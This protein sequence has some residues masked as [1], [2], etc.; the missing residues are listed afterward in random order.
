MTKKKRVCH[1]STVHGAFDGR[2]FYKQCVYLAKE[3]FDVS[4]IVQHDKNEEVSNVKIRRLPKSRG[5]F[6]RFFVLGFLAYFKAIGARAKIVHFHD[7]ELIFVGIGLRL[8]G[9]K[10]IYDNHE[11]VYKQIEGKSWVGKSGLRKMVAKFYQF[12]EMLGVSWFSAI[13]LAED[14]YKDYFESR[15]KRKIKK[16]K[17]I[18]NYPILDLIQPRNQG[19]ESKVV[20]LFYA[21]GLLRVRGIKEVCE[22]VEDIS[23]DVELIL[24]GRWQNE[25]YKNECLEGKG[26][27]KFLGEIPLKEVYPIM[28]T[29]DIG[30]C[31][32]YPVE[33]HLTSNPVKVYE[34][35]A[36]G[37]PMIISNFPSWME[38]FKD[39]SVFVDPTSVE[40]IKEKI[41]WSVSNLEELR[42][43]GRKGSKI[44]REKYSWEAESKRLVAIYNDL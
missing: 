3:G 25:E 29:A 11:L 18:R 15:Y 23:A 13:V 31:T 21:G 22:A 27:V 41:Q 14:G 9:K 34:Y 38:Q 33:N 40:E 8:I 10:V 39:Y 28:K 32:L 20:R 16:I 36:C 4:Y 26:R 17:Y 7:P 30:I 1:I 5:R 42:E 12:F 44:V 19:S 37:L 24:L 2:I 43:R 6:H 35:M